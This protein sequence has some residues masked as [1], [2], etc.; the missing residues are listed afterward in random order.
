VTVT[1]VLR[2]GLLAACLWLPAVAFAQA[3]APATAPSSPSQ[4]PAA[5]QD[6]F[7]PVSQLPPT[8][9]LPA[10][11]LV[12]GAYGF[13]W[14]AVLVYVWSL[15]RRLNAVQKDFDALSKRQR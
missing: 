12:L 1:R 3:P 13:I 8:E 6:G 9:Q 4:P 11:P 7:V 5:A 2:S 10:S 14:L 15:A